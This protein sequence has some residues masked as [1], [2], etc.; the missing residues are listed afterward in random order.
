MYTVIAYICYS[1][2]A[3]FDFSAISESDGNEKIIAQE[4]EHHVLERL[5]AVSHFGNFLNPCEDLLI[6]GIIINDDTGQPKYQA[7]S[8]SWVY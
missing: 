6:R 2:Q 4:R 7:L 8:I 3:W 1:F 5:H